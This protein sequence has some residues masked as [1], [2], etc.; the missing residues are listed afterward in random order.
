MDNKSKDSK[1][2]NWILTKTYLKI[3]DKI[4]KRG[5]EIN[6]WKWEEERSKENVHKWW[7]NAGEEFKNRRN[8]NKY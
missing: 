6:K 2:V 1:K 4:S 5:W 8:E 3:L 7:N